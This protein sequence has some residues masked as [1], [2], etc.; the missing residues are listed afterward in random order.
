[1]KNLLIVTV[2]Y[3][4]I[5]GVLYAQ[6]DSL[7][8][9]VDTLQEVVVSASR[10]PQQAFKAP[11][12]VSRLG[13]PMHN[14]RLARTLPEAL[15]YL[16]GVFVQKTNHGG[17]SP[18]LRGLTGNQTLL[19]LDGIR[20]NN[21]TFRFGP[22]QYPNLIDAFT[23]QRI[24]VLKG[25]GSVQYG[26]D[27][28][29]GVIHA[30]TQDVDF[31]Q[32]KAWQTTAGGRITT[33]HME[34]TARA[35][36]GYS[37]AKFAIAGGYTW[38]QFGDL[39]GGDSTGRQRPSGYN[40]RNWNLKAKLA[41]GK[42]ATITLSAQQ[43]NQY[44]VPLYHRVRLENF[45]YYNFHPQRMLISYARLAVLAKGGPLK[46]W[47][48]TPVYKRST[49]ARQYH[50]NGNANYFY[51]QDAIN[52]IGT[53]VETNWQ[54]AKNW[55]SNTGAEWYYDKVASERNLTNT[56]GT[57]RQRGLYPD[58]SAQLNLSVYSLHHFDFEKLTIEAGLRYNL[59]ENRIPS[60]N[61]SV[62]GAVF[63][64]A[65]VQ[66]SALVGNAS[67][68]YRL[69]QR[70][71][72]FANISTGFRAPGIDDMGTLGLVDFRYE[73]PNYN[74]KPEQNINSEISY[75]FRGKK[76]RIEGSLFYMHLRNLI[77]R[78]RKGTDSLEGYPVFIKT[79]DQEAFIRGYELNGS[80]EVMNH[81]TI[82]AMVSGQHGQNLTRNEPVR[83]IPPTHGLVNITYQMQ[84]WYLMGEVQ[85]AA[86]QS[87]LAQGDKDDN[88]IPKGGTPGWQVVNLHA[89]Y[90]TPRL[91]CRLTAANL[92]NQDFRTH[93]S[94]ING[95]GRALTLSTFFYLK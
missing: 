45:E 22:N 85:W 36:A 5:N 37:S 70:Q 88:R 91:Q 78:V 69:S 11:F 8:L 90:T 24:E 56:A 43:V 95:M 14:E 13:N 48:I 92:L 1:M 20:V 26:S 62:P 42:Q 9:P 57:T 83:R 2:Y 55:T 34:Y 82:T 25:S 89:G 35:E 64:S 93:G 21:A 73:V 44:D 6:K 76:F 71:V 10:Y 54:F 66:T 4:L 16:P 67:V 15:A 59:I 74:L 80:F 7:Q 60:K 28:L 84:R 39:Y 40:E 19:M 18:F 65:N 77:S 31:S 50:R 47:S 72:V 3:L 87:R 94:G 58:G 12:M 79:N 17:G 75:R 38:R 23:L 29:G 49:E 68:M 33:Q 41:V 27:A 53:V 32:H 81:L 86:K 52:S 30:I 46:Q 61:L 63:E 51:E